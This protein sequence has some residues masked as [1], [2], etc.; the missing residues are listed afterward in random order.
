MHMKTNTT[1]LR[2]VLALCSLSSITALSLS[3][4]LQADT[5]VL[6]N[7]NAGYNASVG[8]IGGTTGTS[9]NWNGTATNFRL[10]NS[11]ASGYN[12][13]DLFRFDDD[14]DVSLGLGYI[15]SGSVVSSA[16][17]TLTLAQASSATGTLY[18]API[19]E[20]WTSA[21]TTGTFTA[22]PAINTGMAVSTS[23]STTIAQ[24]ATISFDVTGIVQSW[25]NGSSPSYGFAVYAA[26]DSNSFISAVHNPLRTNLQTPKLAIDYAAIPEPSSVA[27]LAGVGAGLV[28]GTRRRRRASR[29]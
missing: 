7:N 8:G 9:A 3:A 21:A 11:T 16:T 20:A 5:M 28:V 18:V 6:Q 13:T 12:V 27:L 15:S 4:D 23:W 2:R 19:T 17:L 1:S 25:V 10:G 22:L 29:V 26:A 24:S 14:A